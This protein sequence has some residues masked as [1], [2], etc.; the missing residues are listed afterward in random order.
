MAFYS[1]A[2]ENAAYYNALMSNKNKHNDT[3]YRNQITQ[4]LLP[5]NLAALFMPPIW[6]PANGIWITILYYPLWLFADNLFYSAYSNPSP[7]PII[8]SIIVAVVLAVVT[9]FFARI[10]QGYACARALNMGKTKEE[11]IKK[12][13]VWA[14]AMGLL[15]L[16]MIVLATI[17]NLTIRPS[18]G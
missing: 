18:L 9:I 5:I 1:I 11:Y 12:Q 3:K 7:L 17:Y 2:R 14:V 10:S 16:V 15:A 4:G 6:G 13:K 8:L